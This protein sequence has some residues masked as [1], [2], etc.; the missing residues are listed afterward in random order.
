MPYLPP[1]ATMCRLRP[2]H[3][4]IFSAKHPSLVVPY[5]IR[6]CY[7]KLNNAKTGENW[8]AGSYLATV[9]AG[10]KSEVKSEV[11]QCLHKGPQLRSWSS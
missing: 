3:F 5:Y 2:T 4:L 10:G 6:P 11:S 8:M 1:L 9:A 7:C